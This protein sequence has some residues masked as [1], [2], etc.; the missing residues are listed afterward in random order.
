MLEIFS[1]RFYATESDNLSQV[2]SPLRRM[3][4]DIPFPFN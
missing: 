3:R 4:I 1:E 2:H